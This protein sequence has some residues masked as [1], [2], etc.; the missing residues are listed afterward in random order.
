VFFFDRPSHQ[1]FWY[2]YTHPSKEPFAHGYFEVSTCRYVR[3]T[4]DGR[5]FTVAQQGEIETI[6][7]ANKSRMNLAQFDVHQILPSHYSPINRRSNRFADI[8]D[9]LKWT[10]RTEPAFSVA[11]ESLGRRNP[12]YRLTREFVNQIFDEMEKVTETEFDTWLHEVT[13]D[14]WIYDYDPA[15]SETYD[16]FF[17]LKKKQLTVPDAI[18]FKVTSDHVLYE[19]EGLPRLYLL[20]HNEWRK[21]SRHYVDIG[22]VLVPTPLSSPYIV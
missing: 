11:Y 10:G 13:E 21:E 6:L 20:E 19:I 7:K 4:S 17:Q 3:D 12:A 9:R 5:V 16:D 18:K 22:P 1:D 8:I 15:P 14:S 2:A